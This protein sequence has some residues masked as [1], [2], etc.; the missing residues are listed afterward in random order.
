MIHSPLIPIL[1]NFS[2]QIHEQPVQSMLLQMPD[3]P[4]KVLLSFDSYIMVQVLGEQQENTNCTTTVPWEVDIASKSRRRDSFRNL[5]KQ[6]DFLFVTENEKKFLKELSEQESSKIYHLHSVFL[7][8]STALTKAVW[9]DKVL[10]I[11]FSR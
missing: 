2:I 1:L 7:S 4:V 11:R 9:A 5:M 8:W 10:S 3:D 6:V